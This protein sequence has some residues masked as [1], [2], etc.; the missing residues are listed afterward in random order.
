[1]G[2]ILC[3]IIAADLWQL[4]WRGKAAEP[5]RDLAEVGAERG[6]VRQRVR[7]LLEAIDAATLPDVAQIIFVARRIESVVPRENIARGVRAKAHAAERLRKVIHVVKA[8][9]ERNLPG[10]ALSWDGWVVNLC[11]AAIRMAIVKRRHNS[12]QWITCRHDYL[13]AEPRWTIHMHRADAQALAAARPFQV[14]QHGLHRRARAFAYVQEL[15]LD[16]M[17]ATNVGRQKPQLQYEAPPRAQH[18]SHKQMKKNH[19][20]LYCRIPFKTTHGRFFLG[21]D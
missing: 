17:C 11:V 3:W 4:R 9:V 20:P 10:M 5:L 8:F 21:S 6:Y 18:P 13:F 14:A 2:V 1:M 12:I 7:L 19:D 16:A 15:Y